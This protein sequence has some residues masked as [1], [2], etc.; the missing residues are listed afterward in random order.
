MSNDSPPFPMTEEDYELL[1]ECFGAL[2][3]DKLIEETEK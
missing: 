3:I 1:C 2:V